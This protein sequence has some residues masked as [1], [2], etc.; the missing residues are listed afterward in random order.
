[1][2]RCM[3]DPEQFLRT[4]TRE[5][6][7]RIDLGG[8]DNLNLNNTERK[9]GGGKKGTDGFVQDRCGWQ[10]EPEQN[11]RKEGRGKERESKIC[12]E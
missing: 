1:M 2:H 9:K 11:A 6:L 7:Y 4:R 8:V 5:K 12:S 10:R 3:V